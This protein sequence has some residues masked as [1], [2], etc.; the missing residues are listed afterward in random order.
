MSSLVGSFSNDTHE[1]NQS[2]PNVRSSIMHHDVV[3]VQA[4][5]LIY[6]RFL[7]IPSNETK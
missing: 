6:N 4:R 1:Q 5:I 3:L 2:I 7:S